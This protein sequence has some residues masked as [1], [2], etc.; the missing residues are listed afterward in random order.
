MDVCFPSL[1]T[2]QFFPFPLHTV[3]PNSLGSK[4]LSLHTSSQQPMIKPSYHRNRS[5]SLSIARSP[6]ILSQIPLPLIA[7]IS[8]G[9]QT[10]SK[11]P[12]SQYD[13]ESQ[14]HLESYSLGRTRS[15]PHT[16][17]HPIHR[18]HDLEDIASDDGL[19]PL[20]KSNQAL[21]SGKSREAEDIYEEDE[22]DKNEQEE[23]EVDEEELDETLNYTGGFQS[24]DSSEFIGIGLSF[25]AVLILAIA[26]GL[27]TIYDWV[28]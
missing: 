22:N 8:H 10:S 4:S 6:S 17:Q 2:T 14:T 3:M 5:S 11:R 28:L 18:N 16:H 20:G 24:P 26:A 15:N 19:I 21:L 13:L 23:E 9:T 1:L 7:P 27:T 25:G 12:K